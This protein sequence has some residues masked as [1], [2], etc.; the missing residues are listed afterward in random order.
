MENCLW[1]KAYPGIP[2]AW[3]ILFPFSFSFSL[4][5]AFVLFYSLICFFFYLYP[6][7]P[8][9]LKINMV[10]FLKDGK[11]NWVWHR[12]VKATPVSF[13]AVATKTELMANALF[14]LGSGGFDLSFFSRAMRVA[15]R[16]FPIMAALAKTWCAALGNKSQ[17]SPRDCDF[18]LL[19][20]VQ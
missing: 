6:K 8:L 14:S 10:L 16:F 19:S 11:K 4:R 3:N 17:Q 1:N 20:D 9:I 5:E 12:G 7:S 2:V 15:L 18:L 13:P